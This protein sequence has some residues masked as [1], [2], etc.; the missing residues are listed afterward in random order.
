MDG[1]LISTTGTNHAIAFQADLVKRLLT[2]AS[3]QMN[4]RIKWHPSNKTKDLSVTTSKATVRS[5]A[6]DPRQTTDSKDS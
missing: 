6:F 4:R 1:K 3:P 5:L 2:G